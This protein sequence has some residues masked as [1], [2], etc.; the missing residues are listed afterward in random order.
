MQRS[1]MNE[2]A[3]HR[4]SF[5]LLQPRHRRLP[6]QGP[7][8]R[9]ALISRLHKS[10]LYTRTFWELRFANR[11]ASAQGAHP[12]PAS[13][14][15]ASLSAQETKRTT[16]PRAT[17]APCADRSGHCCRHRR[18][19]R[20]PPPLR[21]PPATME[22][23]CPRCGAEDAVELDLV[24]GVSACTVCGAVLAEEPLVNAAEFDEGG[25][26]MGTAVHAADTGGR[27]G[28]VFGW[29]GAMLLAS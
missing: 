2:P 21:R 8:T 9:A 24:Q 12:S 1:R 3:A 11:D 25:A 17:V 14:L 22:G 28:S 7:T 20:L 18:H 6:A 19:R 27:L 13:R 10:L 15:C 26:R 16:Y 5:D 4:S 29:R 23:A